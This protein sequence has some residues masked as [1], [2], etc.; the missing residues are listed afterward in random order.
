MGLRKKLSQYSVVI[1]GLLLG[2]GFAFGGIASYSGLVSGGQGAQSQDGSVPQVPSQKYTESS[3]NLSYREQLFTAAR[4][5][6]VYVNGFYTSE[7]ALQEMRSLESLSRE[8]ERVYVQ[9]LPYDDSV[10]PA[11]FSLERSDQ[12]VVVG[13][14]GRRGTVVTLDNYS[15]QRVTGSIC[16]AVRNWGPEMASRCSLG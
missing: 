2:G 8:F 6:V 9:V 1:V 10:L 5:D 16:E 13:G 7:E 15:N 3:Y 14:A 11:Q 4:N 12:V